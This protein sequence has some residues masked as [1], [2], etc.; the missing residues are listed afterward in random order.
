MVFSMNWYQTQK[1]INGRWIF[2][3]NEW[4]PIIE[5]NQDTWKKSEKENVSIFKKAFIYDKEV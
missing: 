2:S 5:K 4:I 1:H 3:V